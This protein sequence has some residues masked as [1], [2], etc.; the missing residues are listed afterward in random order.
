MGKYTWPHQIA[1]AAYWYLQILKQVG[2]SQTLSEFMDKILMDPNF[3]KRPQRRAVQRKL[4][5]LHELGLIDKRGDYN[6]AKYAIT[7][8]G[9][10]QLGKLSL[11]KYQKQ[12]IE[13][14][15]GQWRLVSFDIPE[16]L[17]EAR[18]HIRRLLKE[19]GFTQLQLSLWIHPYPYL[20]AFNAI[21]KAYG[22][23]EHLIL[24]EV[25]AYSPPDHILK[26]FHKLYPEHF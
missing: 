4:Y 17:R 9:V 25:S 16:T 21:Q 14:W 3:G 5:K 26:H 7:D 22:I 13:K 6:N 24:L 19:L 2:N 8:S 11:L 1:D 23:E 12:Q 18:Y 10:E 20:E 15:D